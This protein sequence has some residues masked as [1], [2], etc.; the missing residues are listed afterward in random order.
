[1]LA[2][3]QRNR[4]PFALLVGMKTDAAI[5]QKSMEIPQKNKNRT[6]L[7]NLRYKTDKYKGREQN[8]IKT[9]KGAK[10][11]RPL[12]TENKL[13]ISGGLLAGGDGLNG[14]GALRR[15]LVMS[16]GCSM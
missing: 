6:T 13:S 5:L 9:G 14:Q 10:H 2:R 3:M 12:N 11:K 16:T 7:W 1:M 15:T 8:N 4:N